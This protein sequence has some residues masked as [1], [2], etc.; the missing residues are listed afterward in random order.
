[1]IFFRKFV[2]MTRGKKQFVAIL[3]SVLFFFL[4]CPALPRQ[5]S[6]DLFNYKEKTDSISR[7][8]REGG[9]DSVMERHYLAI[10]NIWY[11]V[12]KDSGAASAMSAAGYF[13]SRK[14]LPLEVQFLRRAAGFYHR[15][16]NYTL[17][18]ELYLTALG[19]AESG[20][21]PLEFAKVCSGIANLYSDKFQVT[22]SFDD[23]EKAISTQQKAIKTLEPLNDS[24]LLISAYNSLGQKL[25]MKHDFRSA[26][27]FYQKAA[28]IAEASQN[29]PGL[30]LSYENLGA[31]F[32]V[33]GDKKNDFAILS[34]SLFFYEKSLKLAGR[35][36]TDAR[37]GKVLSQISRIYLKM[38]F[39]EKAYEYLDK[40]LK[41]ARLHNETT[42]LRDIYGMMALFHENRGDYKK[43]FHFQKLWV[44][45]K[46]S[47]LSTEA[48]KNMNQLQAVYDNVKQQ[49]EIQLLKKD[50]SIKN[51][52]LEARENTL[53][54]NRLIIIS[55]ICVAVLL[56]LLALLVV[57]RSLIRKKA[58]ESLSKAYET[59]Q[60]QN[61]SITD[62]ITY[63]KRIQDS[64]IANESDLKKV[65]PD[66]FIFYR[67][68]QI[69]SG[70]FCWVCE[71]Q[72]KL[73]LAVADCTGH[74]VPGA[75]MSMVGNTLLKEII[76]QKNISDPGKALSELNK[77]IVNSL[78]QEGGDIM[79]QSDGM[80]ISLLVWDPLTRKALFAGASQNL[81]V[82]NRSGARL[83]EGSPSPA[84]GGF[85]DASPKFTTSQI[86]GEKGLRLF[87]YTDG[88]TDQFGG[89][90]DRK[91]GSG[92][93]LK[94][95]TESAALPLDEQGQTLV[96]GFDAWKG[97][98]KQTDDVLL[99]AI[100]LNFP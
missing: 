11:L 23:L 8:I 85:G 81:I 64:F 70:D 100:A 19:K 68:L 3:F 52:E 44:S 92:R 38:G 14:N 47:L 36:S 39:H 65:F 17:G 53:K 78:N 16:N 74:G 50:Q 84:G 10:Q 99:V 35:E 26:Q 4:N 28:Q 21:L 46:D 31:S 1:M 80:D 6:A 87:L 7:L 55:S 34:K 24:A 73:F 89:E 45:L 43:A 83:I 49:Q 5:T 37:H 67:Q 72:G 42:L 41:I 51:L 27:D 59:I 40:G 71:S 25:M 18:L 22:G 30:I 32:L 88:I 48:M 86:E 9:S 15:A 58:N 79:G 54:R 90:N 95:I 2:P 20:N 75:L 12:N 56:G 77:G 29:E 69:V 62:S 76:I 91:L 82:C 63:A 97:D 33:E 60:A 66:S 13:N 93:L 57:N 94:M 96:K 98:Q 61:K